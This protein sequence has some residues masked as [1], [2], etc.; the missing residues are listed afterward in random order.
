MS[1]V[2]VSTDVY[3]SSV[4]SSLLLRSFVRSLFLCCSISFSVLFFSVMLK[5]NSKL[6]VVVS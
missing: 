4:V 2:L 6:S 5:W 1:R 3:R